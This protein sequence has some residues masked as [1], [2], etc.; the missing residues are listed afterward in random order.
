M[1]GSIIG[2]VRGDGSTSE[3]IRPL[4]PE[5]RAVFNYYPKEDDKSFFS[6]YF[7]YNGPINNG[8]IEY[9]RRVIESGAARVSIALVGSGMSRIFNAVESGI[10]IP[11]GMNRVLGISDFIP[12]ERRQAKIIGTAKELN[13]FLW[14]DAGWSTGNM[15]KKAEVE[16]V[17]PRSIA[18]VHRAIIRPTN[19]ELPRNGLYIIVGRRQNHATLWL[20]NTENVIDEATSG[21]IIENFNQN[22]NRPRDNSKVYFWELK[23]TRETKVTE[24][25]WSY[26]R[27]D[28]H[29]QRRIE[30]YSSFYV[31]L[32]LHVMTDD[33][34]AVEN[35]VIK[36]A[37]EKMLYENHVTFD[38]TTTGNVKVRN[39]EVVFENVLEE[40]KLNLENQGNNSI[41]IIAVHENL[42]NEALVTID[43]PRP[44]WI[45]VFDGYPCYEENGV[46]RDVSPSDVFKFILGDNYRGRYPNLNHACATRVS[47]GLINAGVNVPTEFQ[48]QRGVF[49]GKGFITSAI[50]LM[51]ELPNML[52]ERRDRGNIPTNYEQNERNEKLLKADI[53]IV[54]Q[55]NSSINFDITNKIGDKKGIYIF[56]LPP[57]QVATGHAT[58]WLKGPNG[59]IEPIG[60]TFGET[61]VTINF[62]ELKCK[63]KGCIRDCNKCH[64]NRCDREK[65]LKCHPALR[66]G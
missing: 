51:K 60:G 9:N 43:R 42:R 18:E 48:I 31:D 59:R 54:P 2:I 39:K 50:N 62:W 12:L 22:P 6:K 58:L 64:K 52:G 37:G 47:L 4:R 29:Y 36:R 15:E 40:L 5:W 23:G 61:A 28:G 46:L 24:I 32:N 41:E 56:K 20:G 19:I 63:K 33:G 35:I 3:P 30:N 17:N 65:C 10:E 44:R 57:G 8:E 27:P 14:K 21:Y 55:Q 16:S 38:P 53:I 66:T 7:G 13:T 26:T 34:G 1:A 11:G 45:D 25:Y 49:K